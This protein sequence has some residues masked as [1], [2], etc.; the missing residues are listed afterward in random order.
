MAGSEKTKG[1]GLD[2]HAFLKQ[3]AGDWRSRQLSVSLFAWQLRGTKRVGFHQLLADLHI[4]QCTSEALF[5]LKITGSTRIQANH[6]R[7]RHAPG[8]DYRLSLAAS[9]HTAH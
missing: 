9:Q 8:K 2:S 7:V 3:S 6:C 4:L 1:K 5:W